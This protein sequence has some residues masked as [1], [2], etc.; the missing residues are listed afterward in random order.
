MS[1]CGTFLI[2]TTLEMLGHSREMPLKVHSHAL[3]WCYISGLNFVGKNLLRENYANF[4]LLL[5]V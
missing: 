2:Q 4:N 1:F 5:W 3:I